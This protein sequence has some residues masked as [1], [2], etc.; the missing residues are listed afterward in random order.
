MVKHQLQEDRMRCEGPMRIIEMLRLWELG[1]SQREIARSINSGK[2]TVGE[3]QKR[4]REKGLCHEQAKQMTGEQ[5]TELLYPEAGGRPGKPDPLWEDIQKR[6][7]CGKRVNLRFV[8]EEYRQDNPDG[9]SYSQFCL[10]YK[11]RRNTTGKDVVM[12]Q[13]REPGKGLF[14]DRAGDTLSWV[15]DSGS[16]K[17]LKAQFFVGP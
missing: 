14:V 17:L 3:A 8:W 9:L 5:I 16:G 1:Y 7:D 6:L 15:V 2:S 13:E 12:V 4:C 11:R 10:R